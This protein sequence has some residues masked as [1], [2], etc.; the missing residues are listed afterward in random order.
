MVCLF[1]AVPSRLAPHACPPRSPSKIPKIRTQRSLVVPQHQSIASAYP[2]YL[3]LL[4]KHRGCGGILPV[5]ELVPHNSLAHRFRFSILHFLSSF[6]SNFFPCHTSE[7]MLRKS[8]PCHTSKNA[9]LKALSLPHL[10][11]APGVRRRRSVRHA[12]PAG[13]RP[14]RFSIVR[15]RGLAYSRIT[16]Q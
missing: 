15:V 13:R 2:L 5:L 4:R 10:R 3:P 9:A 6:C 14:G 16:I 8:F 1:G 7:K 11:H 12:R